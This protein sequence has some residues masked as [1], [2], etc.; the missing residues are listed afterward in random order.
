[1]GG[2]GSPAREGGLTR[3]DFKYVNFYVK[4]GIRKNL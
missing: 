1:Y 4:V 3:S 2:V